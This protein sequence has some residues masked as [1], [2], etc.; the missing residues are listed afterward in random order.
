V[1]LGFVLLG[2][3]AG[4]IR[5][6]SELPDVLRDYGVPARVRTSFAVLLAST[7][8]VVGAPLVAGVESRPAAYTCARR[9]ARLHIRRRPVTRDVANALNMKARQVTPSGC[10]EPRDSGPTRGRRTERPS[11]ALGNVGR[12]MGVLNARV[13]SRRICLVSSSASYN[14]AGA[15]AAPR[16]AE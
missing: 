13:R 16:L 3:A 7:E 9:R 2:A 10:D 11:A 6:W 1:T 14:L 15:R 4:K 5:G 8:A 12:A